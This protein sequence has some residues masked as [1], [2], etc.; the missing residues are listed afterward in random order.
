MMAVHVPPM[1]A[2][3]S[4][5]SLSTGHLDQS[6][7]SAVIRQ[8]GTYRLQAWGPSSTQAQAAAAAVA[9]AEDGL[10]N[11]QPVSSTSLPAAVD[12]LDSTQPVPTSASAGYPGTSAI[13]SRESPAGSVTTATLAQHLASLQRQVELLQTS[14]EDL[15]SQ[16][17]AERVARS[18]LE[19]RLRSYADTAA[20]AAALGST[21]ASGLQTSPTSMDVS[22]GRHDSWG[23]ASVGRLASFS[24]QMF[25]EEADKREVRMSDMLAPSPR[26]VKQRMSASPQLSTFSPTMGGA[27]G[28]PSFCLDQ[29]RPLRL[30]PGRPS[31]G[32]GVAHPVPGLPLGSPAAHEK[33]R[34]REP[35]ETFGFRSPLNDYGR[36]SLPVIRDVGELAETSHFAQVPKAPPH[37]GVVSVAIAPQLDKMEARWRQICQETAQL[38]NVMRSRGRL[39]DETPTSSQEL[40]Q[41]PRSCVSS[42]RLGDADPAAAAAA[43]AALEALDAADGS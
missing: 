1:L 26:T 14:H 35:R 28:R 29:T 17:A 40:S 8:G 33:I 4:V 37:E 38:R 32:F 31:N 25:V 6:C 34:P 18:A 42:G 30:D 15:R 41:P 20:A 12:A 23:G 11:T 5:A 7:A 39:R 13:S 9:A 24:D 3:A 10:D 27:D 19:D 43:V 21:H 36:P 2:A 22:L 16:L